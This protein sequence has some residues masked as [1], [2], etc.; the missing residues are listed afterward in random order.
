MAIYIANYNLHFTV[1]VIEETKKDFLEEPV[2]LGAKIATCW[3]CFLLVPIFPVSFYD[4]ET[5]DM[6]LSEPGTAVLVLTCGHCPLF[7]T[8]PLSALQ[9]SATHCQSCE[10]RSSEGGYNSVNHQV[11]N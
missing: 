3:F 8:P 7:M 5:S 6:S 4:Q 1:D 9:V 11:L 2:D 10:P